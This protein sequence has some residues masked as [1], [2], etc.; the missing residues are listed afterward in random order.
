MIICLIITVLNGILISAESE[1]VTVH[2][3]GV[4]VFG[5]Y[6]AAVVA[7]PDTG[8]SSFIADP[9]LRIEPISVEAPVIFFHGAEFSGD[10]VVEVF[11]GSIFEIYPVDGMTSSW[12]TIR[13]S[14]IQVFNPEEGTEY[15]D[16]LPVDFLL[17]YEVVRSWRTLECN[18]VRTSGGI[19][20]GFLYYECFLDTQEF[21]KYPQLLATGEGL[22][23]GVDKVLIFLEPYGDYSEMYLVDP[24]SIFIPVETEESSVY[25][26][27]WMME[28]LSSWNTV[29]LYPGELELLWETW[30]AYVTEPL[31]EG[32]ALVV[33]P[34]SR[35]MINRISSLEVLPDGEMEIT[36][37]RF[38]LGMMP[39]SWSW[40]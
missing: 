30:E 39:V 34:L 6:K 5:E 16:I 9:D 4:V 2:E 21:M 12:N 22:P 17:P 19:N 26:R 38:F 33:F 18:S 23:E 11:N 35:E 1:P 8:L 14:D 40:N 20:E 36:Y 25:D 28:T 10:F 13:W 31:W 29:G 37:G 7:V 3:W 32:D 27:S 15:P 24:E